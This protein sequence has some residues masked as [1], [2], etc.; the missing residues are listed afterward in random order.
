MVRL[1]G[2]LPQSIS[3]I[4]Y[5]LKGFHEKGVHDQSRHTKILLYQ[6]SWLPFHCYVTCKTIYKGPSTKRKSHNTL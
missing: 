1:L 2:Y 6:H 4:V 3:Q 5:Y